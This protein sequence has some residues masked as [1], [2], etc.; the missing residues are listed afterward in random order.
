[1][2]SSGTWTFSANSTGDLLVD[3]AYAGSKGTH[4]PMHSQDI[5]QLLAAIPA[6]KCRGRGSTDELLV[7]NSV[8][9]Q[10]H[11]VHRPGDVRWY[12]NQCDGKGRP[13]AAALPAVRWL[14]AG[15]AG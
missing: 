3:V 1:M 2:F 10:L 15:G 14:F 12:G 4:L 5:D 11:G 8:C 6:A 7:P 9:R 13:V